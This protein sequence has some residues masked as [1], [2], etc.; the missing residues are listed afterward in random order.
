LP[1]FAEEKFL[2]VRAVAVRTGTPLRANAVN[3]PTT[4]MLLVETTQWLCKSRKKK[5]T[6]SQSAKVKQLAV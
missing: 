2:V 4:F 5:S 3:L 1:Y 6:R